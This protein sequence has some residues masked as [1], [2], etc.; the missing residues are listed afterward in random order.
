M[1]KDDNKKN[2]KN[3][4]NEEKEKPKVFKVTAKSDVFKA[5]ND[6]ISAVVGD[7]KFNITPKCISV[8]VAD[9][10]HVGM[11]HV[12]INNTAFG[13]YKADDMELGVD[14]SKLSGILKLAGPD[15]RVSLE[16]DE[17]SNRLIVRIGSLV[18][19][20]GVLDTKDMH[21]VKMPALDLPSKV[22]M[23]SGDFSKGIRA[24]EMI[25]DHLAL[26]VNKDNF[27]ISAD[28][29][30]SSDTVYIKLPK[31]KLIELNTD[32]KHRSMFA[33]DY[34][35]NIMKLVKSDESLI[36]LIGDNMPIKIEFSIADKKGHVAY[37]VAPRIEAE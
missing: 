2:V 9:V 6:V 8:T 1:N 36:L 5:F 7:A 21:D 17:E 27:E 31:S 24:S 30:S 13:E 28:S 19:K 22:V 4:K 12:Y 29:D 14:V 33:I 34:L 35:N 18:R 3:I 37:M 32:D 25:S 23:L 26:S 10:A 20:M 16:Y 15:D 11:V